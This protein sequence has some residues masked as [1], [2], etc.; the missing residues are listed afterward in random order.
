ME[1]VSTLRRQRVGEPGSHRRPTLRGRLVP[2]HGRQAR[3]GQAGGDW[4]DEW[5]HGGAM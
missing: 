5:Y 3:A 4:K 2:H 1:R